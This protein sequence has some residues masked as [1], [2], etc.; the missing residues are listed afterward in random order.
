[1]RE[2]RVAG[3]L[4]QAIGRIR[5]RKMTHED[6]TC[7]PCDLFVRLSGFSA[8]TRANVI[9]DLLASQFPNIKIGEWVALSIVPKK[10]GRKSD[11]T[12]RIRA[13]LLDAAQKLQPGGLLDLRPEALGV[14]ASGRFYDVIANAQKP[15]RHEYQA[16][17]ALGCDVEPGGYR[18]GVK[19]RVPAKLVRRGLLPQSAPNPS[20]SYGIAGADRHGSAVAAPPRAARA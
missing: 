6:G 17:D 16:L 18:D 2:K 10:A 20:G 9:L 1:M 4:A 11:T 14:E 7:E 13:A 8:H 19:G 15:E 5:L 3:T 12:Q